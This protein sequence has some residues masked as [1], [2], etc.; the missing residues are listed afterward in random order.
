M[1]NIFRKKNIKSLISAVLVVVL[2][3]TALGGT[4]SLLGKETKTISPSA[5][6]KGDLDTSGKYKKSETSIYTEDMFECQGLTVEVDFEADLKYIV[7][8]YRSNGDYLGT[9][10]NL[11]SEYEKGEDFVN[12]KY[13]RIVIYP[14]L[15]DDK[16]N[17]WEVRGY[18]KQLTITV[19]K[20]QS[21][22]PVSSQ[23]LPDITSAL[24]SDNDFY[25]SYASV[26]NDAPFVLAEDNLTAFAG[27]HITKIGIPVKIIKD[28]SEDC[29]FK[30]RLVSGNGSAAFKT[31][32]TYELK[33]EANTFGNLDKVTSAEATIPTGT[34]EM[35]EGKYHEY[36][37]GWYKVDQ[38]VY[39][40]VDIDVKSGQTLAFGDASDTVVSAYRRDDSSYKFYS[41]ATKKVSVPH[42]NLSLYFDVW[43][44]E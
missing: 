12:A 11:Y 23:V 14:T 8:Y 1:K 29:V 20:N 34:Y 33:I 6:V 19:N 26:R 25:T 17:F 40:D 42:E 16:I 2:T 32:K 43:Y 21:F 41:L 9:S 37:E 15:E 22:E 35:E 27:K 7:Y 13:A 38:W 4:I 30:V 24:S 44:E 10:G 18:A 3:V 36:Y 28:V 5:F 39:F 31:L